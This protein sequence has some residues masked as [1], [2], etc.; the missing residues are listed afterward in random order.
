MNMSF[1]TSILGLA[2]T[3]CVALAA[4]APKEAVERAPEAGDVAVAKV[5]DSTV[6]VSD[7]KRDAVAQGLIGEGE[8]LDVSSELFRQVLDGL[9]DQRLLSAEA[10]RRK[11]DQDPAAQ[12]RL[13]AARERILGDIL[14]EHSVEKAVNDD[15]IRGLYQELHKSNRPSEEFRA[16]QIVTATLAEAEA[17][18]KLLTSGATFESLAMARSIDAATRFSGGDLG[19]F[20]T[21][22]MP[23]GYEAA[24]KGA[25]VGQIVGP[26]MTQTGWVMMKIEDRRPE[27]PISLEEARPQIVRF[28]TLGE[29]RDLLENL[30]KKTKV[31]M[32]V[33]RPDGAKGREPQAAPGALPAPAP[34]PAMPA[35]PAAPTIPAP[36][37]QKGPVKAPAA[38][39]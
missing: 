14:V 6:W 31:D 36:A 29:V 8:P 39:P 2:V 5:G 37:P 24:L 11:L 12:R 3:L 10:V 21:D 30:R 38:K 23:E 4:C 16:R 33:D 20:T 15:A 22:V 26:F 34:A 18:K 28:L 35:M 7:V 13:T 17:A 32:L 9:I 19:Y 25:R 1:K 27:E